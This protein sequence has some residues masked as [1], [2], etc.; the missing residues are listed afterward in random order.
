MDAYHRFIARRLGDP[1]H[2]VR[3]LRNFFLVPLCSRSFGEFWRLWNPIFGYVLLFHVYKP[4]R[5]RLP[6]PLAAYLTFLASGFL[7]H[8][9]PFSLSADLY[10]GRP[11][12]PV[13]T[14]LFAIFGGLAQL[15]ESL[16]IDLSRSPP[17]VRA[18]S[19]LGWLAS[20]YALRHVLLA[21]I[22]R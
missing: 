20:G 12:S 18:A 15:S 10:R 19:N 17:W 4:L 1:R 7:L 9:L 21:V 8:D 16:G 2:P 13:V 14:L 22:R 5:R 11:A 3:F 6:R